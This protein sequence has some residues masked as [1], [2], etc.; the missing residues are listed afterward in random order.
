FI[1]VAE[2]VFAE[3]TRGIAEWL[4]HLGNGRIFR[5]QSD[6]GTGH[7]DFGQAGAERVL[8]GDESCAS[9]SAALLA[10]VVGKGDTFGGDAVDVWRPVAHHATAE[11]ADVPCTDVIAPEDQDIRLLCSHDLFLPFKVYL[12]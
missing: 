1:A 10:V 8:A 7:S 12:Y 4:E 9:S 2:M 6:S 3:L 11:V 5:L